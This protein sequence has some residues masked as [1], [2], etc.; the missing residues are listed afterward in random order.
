MFYGF[1]VKIRDDE[2]ETRSHDKVSGGSKLLEQ[3]LGLP[4]DNPKLYLWSFRICTA[5]DGPCC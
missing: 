3:L 4:T 5:R 2:V 1:W